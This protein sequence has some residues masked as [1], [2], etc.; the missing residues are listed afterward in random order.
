M[1]EHPYWWDTVP[2]ATPHSE[3]RTQNSALPA[4]ADVVIVGAGYTGLSAARY[5]ARGGASVAVLEREQ[6]GWG[7]SSRNGGQVLTGLKL[8]ASALVAKFGR[9]RA[10]RLFDVA[11]D[12][13]ARLEQLIA[14]EAI[15]C[16]YERVG[17]LCAAFK[18]S[19]ADAFL[20]EQE[21]LARVFDHPVRVVPRPN[22]ARRSAATRITVSWSTSAAGR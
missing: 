13:I 20:E 14:D 6:V 4:R 18:P 15:D 9:A 7:A 11:S 8:E 19:H 21:L 22:S 1:K 12:S 17:H 10:R 2:A 3:L 16:E 5:L